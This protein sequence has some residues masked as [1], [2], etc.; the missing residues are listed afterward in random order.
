MLPNFILDGNWV[1]Y[2]AFLHGAIYVTWR[3]WQTR[4]MPS[5]AAPIRA[6]E[7][8]FGVGLFPQ[9]LM[10][11]SVM[12][13]TIVQGLAQS[14]QLSLSVAGSYALAAMW[15]ERQDGRSRAR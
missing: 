6:E 12:S 4:R 11:L 14:S 2:G 1:E 5:V 8:A 15:Q 3:I 9:Y 10:L 13:S 7:F